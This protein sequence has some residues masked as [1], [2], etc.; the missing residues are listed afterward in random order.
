MKNEL[1]PAQRR[2]YRKLVL[3]LKWR[4]VNCVRF[5]IHPS[6]QGAEAIRTLA[7]M[8]LLKG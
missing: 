5:G 8:V 1:T 6:V 7:A 4:A 3:T 2:A